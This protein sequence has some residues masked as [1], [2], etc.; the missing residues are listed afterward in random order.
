[1]EIEKQT[2]P[3]RNLTERTESRAVEPSM[4]RVK[5][6]LVAFFPALW[7]LGGQSLFDLCTDCAASALPDSNSAFASSKQ[8]PSHSLFS[9]DIST[10]VAHSRVG[11]FSAKSHF[12]RLSSPP[13]CNRTKQLLLRFP[14]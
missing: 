6:M 5:I 2:M 11:K 8:C 3:R 14:H 12:C 10:R 13:P 4:S 1:M 9:S 7:L